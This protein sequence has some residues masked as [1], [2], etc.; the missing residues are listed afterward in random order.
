MRYHSY[1]FRKERFFFAFVAYVNS[2][3]ISDFEHRE[4]YVTDVYEKAREH[5]LQHM[6]VLGLIDDNES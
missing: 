2:L 1:D 4:K 5:G 3:K 6:V